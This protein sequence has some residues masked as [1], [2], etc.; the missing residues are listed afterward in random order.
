MERGHDRAG[1][2]HQDVAFLK[3]SLP[4][5]GKLRLELARLGILQGAVSSAGQEDLAE[6]LAVQVLASAI[7]FVVHGGLYL[8]EDLR[9]GR[10][11]LDAVECT[12]D[13]A[14]AE[15]L[16]CIKCGPVGV[17]Y[18]RFSFEK[19]RVRRH[20]YTHVRVQTDRFARVRLDGSGGAERIDRIVA[21]DHLKRQRNVSHAARQGPHVIQTGTEGDDAGHRYPSVGWLQ[22]DHAAQ[23][24]GN[25]DR[26]G[27]VRA[28]RQRPKAGGDRRRG[29]AGRAA[30]LVSETTRILYP[31]KRS[32]RVRDAA[33]ANS[34]RFVLPDDH[35]AG[36]A[37]A[38][39]DDRVPRRR[40]RVEPLGRG[41]RCASSTHVDHILQR[42]GHA[43]QRPQIDA[44]LK[45]AFG[46]GGRGQRLVMEHR[47]EGVDRRIHRLDA[48]ECRAGHLH[49]GQPTRAVRSGKLL[50]GEIRQRPI[51]SSRLIQSTIPSP[52]STTRV[53][54]AAQSR[55][56]TSARR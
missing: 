38:S 32:V 55:F 9:G 6:A 18:R 47:D 51:R 34:W 31:A 36:A 13:Q 53:P 3:Q 19:E 33:A 54:V 45:Q 28:E 16:E 41:A 20:A 56:R 40:F 12:F 29:S 39:N 10:R 23:G 21:G 1:G 37:K 42:D 50:R 24:G 22:P 15:A 25:A 43:L 4:R 17:Q 11:V 48:F 14:Q 46:S 30:G 44:H 7:A 27:G 52:A 8:E 35:G 26:L 2:S 5:T 49:W